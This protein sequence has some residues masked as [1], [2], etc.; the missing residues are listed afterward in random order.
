M[1]G[2]DDDDDVLLDTDVKEG[3]FVVH[4]VDDGELRR[5]IVELSYLAH[6]GFLKLLEKAAEEFGFKQMGILAI[7]CRYTDL[8]TV[9][10]GKENNK[11]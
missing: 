3:H 5:F 6:P 10:E 1:D 11:E 7:P 4:T 2:K 8:Q 9:L